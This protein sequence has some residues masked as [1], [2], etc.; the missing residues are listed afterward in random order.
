[1]AYGDLSTKSTPSS[2]QLRS[3]EPGPLCPEKAI[4]LWS[5][6]EPIA[7]AVIAEPTNARRDICDLLVMLRSFELLNIETFQGVRRANSEMS[8]GAR[9]ARWRAD[10]PRCPRWIPARWE[11]RNRRLRRWPWV[12]PSAL[13]RGL[14][15]VRVHVPP[16]IA[17]GGFMDGGSDGRKVGSDVMFETVLADVAEQLL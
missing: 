3:D 7:A 8:Q 15:R 17:S 12:I 10:L 9:L 1:L 14:G 16:E 11:F 2:F 4:R 13:V 6:R 5:G